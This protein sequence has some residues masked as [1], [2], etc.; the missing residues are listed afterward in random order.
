MKFSYLTYLRFSIA[1]QFSKAL[2]KKI[3]PYLS[4]ICD[5]NQNGFIPGRTMTTTSIG[6]ISTMNYI[7]EQNIDAQMCSFDVKKAYDSTLY[8]VSNEI[9][10]H[11]FPTHF[12]K[13]WIS[14][15]NGGTYQAIV[16]KC[17]S[18]L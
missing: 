18:K 3:T 2:N 5:E 10:K 9:I 4:K 7:K 11:I 8:S 14:L 16:N 1:V 12:A 15:T 6:I 13:S 17:K